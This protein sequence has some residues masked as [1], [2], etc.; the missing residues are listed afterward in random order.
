MNTQRTIHKKTVRWLSTLMLFGVVLTMA[1]PAG[2]WALG[3]QSDTDITNTATI[4]YSVNSVGQEVIESSPAGNSNPG[5]GAGAPTLFKVDN[6]VRVVVAT[7]G[8]TA[9]A[10]NQS[11]AALAFTVTNTGNTTQGY[12]VSVVNGTTN[13]PMTNVRIFLDVNNDGLWD[14]GD[15]EYS[16]GAF[17]KNLDP[18]GVIGTDDVMQVLVVADAP[19]ATQAL[20]TERDT[21]WLQVTTLPAG[22]G[23]PV[24]ETNAGSADD[25][26]LVD[27]VFGDAADDAGG[28]IDAARNGRHA[29][30]GDFYV[31]TATMSVQKTSAVVEDPILGVSA[32]AKAIPGAR[33]T[34]TITIRNTGGTQA[35]GVTVTDGIPA[36][37]SYATGL[38]TI[39]GSLVPDS[40]GPVTLTGS[41]ATSISVAVGSVAAGAT[42]T[43]TFDAIIN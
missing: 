25:P 11:N 23:A 16:A 18:N 42:A 24:A 38:T 40:G 2:V 36:N 13:I 7:M 6:V 15:V 1:F 31:A 32:N 27:I 29:D 37:T 14:A 10:P 26:A 33:V 21:Y 35:D 5:V 3:T 12:S 39:N 41:P 8:D 9:V 34:Y 4:A 30:S 17:I 43:V 20:D 19:D 22:G 28:S